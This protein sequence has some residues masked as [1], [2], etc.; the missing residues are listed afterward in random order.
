[1][2]RQRSELVAELGEREVLR[3]HEGRRRAA[4]AGG[5]GEAELLR[6]NAGERGEPLAERIQARELRLHLAELHR[7]GVQVL[8]HEGAAT[9]GF[10]FLRR[11]HELLQHRDTDLGGIAQ[12][13][14]VQGDGRA[15]KER[16]RKQARAGQMRERKID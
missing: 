8:L 11:Q 1:M 3:R 2:V 9:L 7:H 16:E 10:G 15:A 13:E 12:R 4:Q 14:P 6:A 5:L